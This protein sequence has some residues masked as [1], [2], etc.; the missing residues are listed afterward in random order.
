[1]GLKLAAPRGPCRLSRAGFGLSAPL[2]TQFNVILV[3]LMCC[4]GSK[5]CEGQLVGE[6]RGEHLSIQRF[7]QTSGGFCPHRSEAEERQRKK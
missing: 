6:R 3:P 7:S 2:H 5:G 4:E 1:M